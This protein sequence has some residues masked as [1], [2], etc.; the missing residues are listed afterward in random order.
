MSGMFR[1]ST[2]SAAGPSGE[3]LDRLETAARLG[4]ILPAHTSRS[5][6]IT[7]RRIVGESSTTRVRSMGP[8]GP[9]FCPI[10]ARSGG[11]RARFCM[12]IRWACN[13]R[14]ASSAAWPSLIRYPTA[15][16]FFP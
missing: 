10:A 15:M 13:S 5:D 6:A 8:Q 4:E 1:S 14:P 11:G 2:I 7:I 9:L 16:K 12:K 3:L